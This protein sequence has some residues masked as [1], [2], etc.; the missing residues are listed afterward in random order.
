M[1]TMKHK[2]I[3]V[4]PLAVALAACELVLP[5]DSL[6]TSLANGPPSSDG[7]RRDSADEGGRPRGDCTNGDTDCADTTTPRTCVNG[8]WTNEPAC[9]P[10]STCANGVCTGL[11]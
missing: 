10:P 8:T 4:L 1:A 5:T 9:V 11:P 7:G 3:R 2:V 6:S